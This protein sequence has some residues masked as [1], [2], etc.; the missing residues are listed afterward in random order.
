ME[1]TDKFFSSPK[2]LLKKRIWAFSVDLIAIVI[3]QRLLILS[4]ANFLRTFFYQLPYN[5][6]FNLQTNMT[7][8][9]LSTLAMVF[10]GYFFLSYYLGEGKTP[11]KMLFG[12]RVYPDHRVSH[13]R[14]HLGFME[15]LSR[16]VSYLFCY[17]LGSILFLMPFLRVDARGVPDFL[18]GTS[19]YDEEEYKAYLK[20]HQ[21]E[22]LTL[23]TT[24]KDDDQQAA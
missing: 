13:D 5:S 12:L 9:H 20:A 11:G 14:H 3:M 21:E 15:C 19:V 23:F 22:Q 2:L 16:S 4:F 24:D 18:S 7:Q 8:I 10:V 1:S 6:Q 17:L